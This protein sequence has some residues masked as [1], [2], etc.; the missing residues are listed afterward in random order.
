MQLN[1]F[2][3]KD[4]KQSGGKKWPKVETPFCRQSKIAE[5]ICQQRT[6]T[7]FTPCFENKIVLSWILCLNPL[8]YFQFY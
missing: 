6:L 4:G 2:I 3:Q 5:V 8:Y 1:M 7:Q